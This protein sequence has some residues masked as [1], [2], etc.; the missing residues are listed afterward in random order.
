MHAGDAGAH[1]T[2]SPT[3]VLRVLRGL[4]IMAKS[5]SNYVDLQKEMER[6]KYD[7]D[8]AELA[9]VFCKPATAITASSTPITISPVP[10]SEAQ[11][12][13][14]SEVLGFLVE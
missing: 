9:P 5:N 13:S 2:A 3:G 10:G 14:G 12:L 7:E 11:R 1:L 4:Y 8:C 6:K